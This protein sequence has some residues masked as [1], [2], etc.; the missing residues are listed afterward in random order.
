MIL[1]SW[2]SMQFSKTIVVEESDDIYFSFNAIVHDDLQITF[3]MHIR[4]LWDGVYYYRH[5]ESACGLLVW[6]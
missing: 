2:R 5:N 3:V 6:A 4:T 1:T